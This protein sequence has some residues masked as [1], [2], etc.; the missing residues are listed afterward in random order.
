MLKIKLDAYATKDLQIAQSIISSGASVADLKNEVSRR[1]ES[2]GLKTNTSKRP[3]AKYVL[4]PKC[5]SRMV[6]V[7]TSPCEP[8]IIGCKKCR[9]SKII[10]DK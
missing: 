10:G 4:C 1:L 7:K 5:G 3:V 2:V 6:S 9:Y 8:V